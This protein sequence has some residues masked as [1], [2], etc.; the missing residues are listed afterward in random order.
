ML[1]KL[2]LLC[3]WVA[4]C[5]NAPNQYRIEILADNP[6]FEDVVT[7]FKEQ[8]SDFGYAEGKDTLYVLN[9]FSASL[10]PVFEIRERIQTANGVDLILSLFTGAS[11]VAREA[12]T[13]TGKPM[14]FAYAAVE[15]TGLVESIR[16]P[17]GTATGVRYPGPEQIGKRLEILHR[18]APD[19]TRVCVAHARDYPPVA[20][21]LSAL[22]ALARSLG[23]TL[24]ELEVE[25]LADLAKELHAR[26]QL[27]D[28]G[29]D[30]ILLMPDYV[31]HSHDGWILIRDFAARHDL[32]VAGSFLY[33]VEQGALFGNA[34]DLVDVGRQAASLAHKILQGIPAGTIPV[35]SPEQELY[36]NF[37][38]AEELGLEIPEGLLRQAR[39]IV[40]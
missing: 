26:G 36:I 2:A 18:I 10:D 38:R 35:V 7:G 1:F 4:G 17:G 40:Q 39:I 12:A 14:V 34:N 21:A 15:D 20:P 30:A 23:V 6:D 28:P 16:D 31:N 32:P 37:K 24:V 5:D 13:L 8:M 22:R 33:T 27:P 11:L 19:H 3:F 29:M 25:D 9:D